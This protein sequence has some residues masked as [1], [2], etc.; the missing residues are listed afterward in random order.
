MKPDPAD[1]TD[2]HITA[3]HQPTRQ[4][5]LDNTIEDSFPASDP[6]SSV[7]DPDDREALDKTKS[8]ATD[9]AQRRHE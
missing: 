3:Q 2:E 1:C 4:A 5:A 7:P 8:S 9:I 6:P